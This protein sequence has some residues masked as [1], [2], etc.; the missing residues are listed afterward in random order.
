VNQ[1]TS[2]P[3]L[4]DNEQVIMGLRGRLGD[5]FRSLNLIHDIAIVCDRACDAGSLRHQLS[6]SGVLT[7]ACATVPG[8]PTGFPDT[9]PSGR[10][11]RQ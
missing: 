10:T 1:S 6:A 11:E 9:L 3:L 4:K 8:N 7:V 2:I 5:M